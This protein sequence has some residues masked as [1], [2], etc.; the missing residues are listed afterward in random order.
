M[1][2]FL[3]SHKNMTQEIAYVQQEF[4]VLAISFQIQHQKIVYH[5]NQVLVQV[6]ACKML[7]IEANREAFHLAMLLPSLDQLSKNTRQL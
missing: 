6:E 4:A 5:T 2:L 1:L 3:Y 7:L